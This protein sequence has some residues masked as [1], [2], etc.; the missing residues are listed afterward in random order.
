[1]LEAAITIGFGLY[2]ILRRDRAGEYAYRF[3]RTQPTANVKGYQQLY[4]VAGALFVVF[5]IYRLLRLLL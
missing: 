2:F 5:G 4:L 1:M 3:W